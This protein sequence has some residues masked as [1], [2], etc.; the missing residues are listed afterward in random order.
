MI[1]TLALAA[2]AA[3][4][5]NAPSAAEDAGEAKVKAAIQSLVPGAT[6]D[7]I[8]E[9]TLPNFY[10]VVLAGQVIYVSRDGRYLIQGSVYDVPARTDLTES[11]R[12]KLRVEGLK[13]AGPERRIIYGPKDAKYRLTVFTDIDCGYCRRM[14]QHMDEYNRLGIA[15]EYLFFPRA[16]VGSESFDKAVSVWC[17]DDRAKALTDAKAGVA[18]DKKQ[19]SNPIEADYALGNKIG[20]NGTPAVFTS[21][22]V[23]IGGYMAPDQLIQ[24]LEQL[25]GKP[26]GG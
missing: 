8:A 24:R 2:L 9:S 1:R 17:S 10:E 3:L 26:A 6:I 12:A 19:C 25:E 7:S 21:Q 23:Q 16:G 15:I 22:G 5:L 13:E 11:A 4:T 18:L 14:H 20:V